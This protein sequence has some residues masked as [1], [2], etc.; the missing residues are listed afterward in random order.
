MDDRGNL[1]A[2]T[3]DDRDRLAALLFD[4]AEKVGDTADMPSNAMP[5]DMS[6]AEDLAQLN[7]N[8]RRVFYSERRRGRSIVHAMETARN[9]LPER[10]AK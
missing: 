2:S 7:H 9:S 3:Q 8:C 1:Y 10:A 4:R 6:L 5:M